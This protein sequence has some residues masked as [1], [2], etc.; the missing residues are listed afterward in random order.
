MEVVLSP[1]SHSENS[2][3]WSP[4]NTP[5]CSHPNVGRVRVVHSDYENTALLDRETTSQDRQNLEHMFVI[6][7]YQLRHNQNSCKSVNS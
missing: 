6:N 7:I 3:A 4:T 1:V 2:K 5:A